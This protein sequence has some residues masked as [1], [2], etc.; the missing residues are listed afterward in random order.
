VLSAKVRTFIVLVD[1]SGSHPNLM[2]DLSASLDVALDRTLNAIVVPRDAIRQDGARA[3]VRV[4]RGE[5]FEDRTVTVTATN[6][7]EAMLSS[8]LEDGTTVA[9]NIQSE[10]SP[11][12]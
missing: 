6:A 7:H 9:R 4:K 3:I 12:R 10:T 1:V 8:G 11:S 2:P 5:R